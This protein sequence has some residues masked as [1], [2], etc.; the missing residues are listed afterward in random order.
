MSERVCVIRS[1]HDVDQ[2][3]MLPGEKLNSSIRWGRVES[4]S[5]GVY[6]SQRPTEQMMYGIALAVVVR[7]IQKNPDFRS[8]ARSFLI[9]YPVKIPNTTDLRSRIL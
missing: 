2:C 8:L 3:S 9:F 4:G 6:P 5:G 1:T 7:V